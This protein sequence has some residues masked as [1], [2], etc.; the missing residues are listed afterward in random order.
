VHNTDAIG[1]MND[2]PVAVHS[3]T[4]MPEPSGLEVAAS[5]TMLEPVFAATLPAEMIPTAGN[6]DFLL[7]NVTLDPGAEGPASSQSWTQTRTC[8]PGPMMTHVIEG[9]LS[10]RV[11]GRL[12]VFRGAAGAAG[13]VP[14]GAEVTLAPGDTAVF[15][16]E[17]PATLANRGSDVV[18]IVGGGI[19]AGAVRSGP[20]AASEYLDYNEEYSVPQLPPG[21]LDAALVRAV[22][23][24]DGEV[25]APPPGALVLEV[26]AGGDADI[27]QSADGSL[28]NIGPE[29]ETI[30]VLTLVPSG[31]T[32]VAQA[33]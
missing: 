7:W 2:E 21:A 5:E 14:P 11:D 4:L 31:D 29:V 18:R 13:D 8:C 25:P 33:P 6:L 27:V 30:Y 17:R 3:A 24:P 12:R 9:E 28:R 23:T 20:A 16:Y 15:S 1:N 22:L 10:V 32:K 19:F 26:G